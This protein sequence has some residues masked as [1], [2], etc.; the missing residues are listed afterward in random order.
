MNECVRRCEICALRIAAREGTLLKNIFTHWKNSLISDVLH[1]FTLHSFA[2]NILIQFNGLLFKRIYFF[3]TKLNKKLLKSLILKSYLIF[4]LYYSSLICIENIA[5]WNTMKLLNKWR[6][7]KG[8]MRWFIMKWAE[9]L[10]EIP[11]ECLGKIF[12]C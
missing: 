4:K 5:K 2:K 7:M 8:N 9:V 12:R 6:H 1:P 3:F 11:L 10:C